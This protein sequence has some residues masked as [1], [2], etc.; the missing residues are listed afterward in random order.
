[1]NTNLVNSAAGVICAAL[2]QG[3]VPAGI[4]TALEAAGLLMSPETAAELER[5]RARVAELEAERSADK[6]TALL[7][8]TQALTA[9]ESAPGC[10]RCRGEK[11]RKYLKDG[12]L[13][14]GCPACGLDNDGACASCRHRHEVDAA[15]ETVI[16][17]GGMNSRRCQCTGPK[18]GASC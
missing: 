6:L 10:I 2:T 4:A 1:M 15:C 17:T 16:P 12:G 7:A 8:P 11:A 3:R 14:G 9:I 13:R 5:L 18:D